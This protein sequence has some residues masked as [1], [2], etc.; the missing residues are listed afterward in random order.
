MIEKEKET[1][2]AK[3]NE[4]DKKLKESEIKCQQKTFEIEKE[5]TKWNLEKDMLETQRTDAIDQKNRL[6][7]AKERLV[8][9]NEKLKNDNKNNRRM[10]YGAQSAISSQIPT[11]LNKFSKPDQNTSF[12]HQNAMNVNTSVNS[13]K[14][15]FKNFIGDGLEKFESEKSGDMSEDK[16]TTSQKEN[17]V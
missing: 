14:F 15:G 13:G 8:W 3:I 7:K 2:K 9:E 12:G 16:S 11:Y 1:Y 4:I 17:L 10:M 5:K 6:E